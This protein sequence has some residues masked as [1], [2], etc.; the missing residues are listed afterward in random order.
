M[1]LLDLRPH[2]C[3]VAFQKR[4]VLLVAEKLVRILPSKL[5]RELE[6]RLVVPSVSLYCLDCLEDVVRVG[7]RLRYVPESF[8]GFSTELN[9]EVFIR[10]VYQVE[11]KAPW[12]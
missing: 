4:T 12:L 1:Q 5:F 10:N 11:P 9:F 2:Q 3:D 6:E 8:I 7:L